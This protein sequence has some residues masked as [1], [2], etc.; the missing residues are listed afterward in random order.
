MYE[1]SSTKKRK[2]ATQ[3]SGGRT[4]QPKGMILWQR[5]L[6]NRSHAMLLNWTRSGKEGQLTERSVGHGAGGLCS[7]QDGKTLESFNHGRDMIF[8]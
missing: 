2:L 7:R 1:L 4:H 3:G 8:F 5:C 6:R